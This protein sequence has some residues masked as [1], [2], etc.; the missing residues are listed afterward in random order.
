MGQPWYQKLGVKVDGDLCYLA[1]DL[2]PARTGLKQQW[3]Q[4]KAIL[5]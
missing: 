2:T 1:G 4:L 5:A 3:C